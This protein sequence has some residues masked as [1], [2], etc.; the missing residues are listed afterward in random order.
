MNTIHERY[1]VTTIER[2]AL[3]VVGDLQLDRQR[4]QVTMAGRPVPLRRRQFDLLAALAAANG[5]VLTR[6]ALLLA[7]GSG[8]RDAHTRTID[9]QVSQLRALLTPG[10]VAIETVR[11]VGYRLVARPDEQPSG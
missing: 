4:R 8:A 9:M 6:A 5:G 11:G 1:P 3:V 10:P 7:T 2:G